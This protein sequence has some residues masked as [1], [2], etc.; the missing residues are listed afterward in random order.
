MP[1]V[2]I[3]GGGGGSDGSDGNEGDDSNVLLMLMEMA[4]KVS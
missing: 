1:K 3:S 2:I 4:F